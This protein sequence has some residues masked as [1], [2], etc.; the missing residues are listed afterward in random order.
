MISICCFLSQVA[1]GFISFLVNQHTSRMKTILKVFLSSLRSLCPLVRCLKQH[2]Q[3]IWAIAIVLPKKMITYRFVQKPVVLK[4]YFRS[5]SK[6]SLR[7]LINAGLL[8]G[9]NLL[10]SNQVNVSEDSFIIYTPQVQLSIPL[11]GLSRLFFSSRNIL[12]LQNAKKACPH[13]I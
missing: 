2:W 9:I 13:E 6:I 5:Y 8:F 11:V 7:C 12:L 1:K 10:L 4:L 3:T